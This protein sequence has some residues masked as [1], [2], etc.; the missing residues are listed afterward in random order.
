MDFVGLCTQLIQILL[1]GIGE[2]ATGIGGGLNDLVTNIFTTTT[3]DTTT[4]SIVAAV[5]ACFGGI[6]LA[7]GLGRKVV[8]WV[9]S[10]GA[11]K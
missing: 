1:S 7:V 9:M 3:G 11:R 6:A 4:I 2:M 5:T 10:L 8:G